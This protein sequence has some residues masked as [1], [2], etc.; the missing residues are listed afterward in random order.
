MTV[1]IH[2]S[3]SDSVLDKSAVIVHSTPNAGVQD[4]RY[5]YSVRWLFQSGDCT[6]TEVYVK[7]SG[8]YQV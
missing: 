3:F 6:G 5:T 8:I 1:D 4:C 7:I 2:G